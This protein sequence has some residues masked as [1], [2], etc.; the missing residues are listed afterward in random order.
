MLWPRAHRQTAG[1]ERSRIQVCGASGAAAHS[2]TCSTNELNGT[3]QFLLLSPEKTSPSK[4]GPFCDSPSVRPRNGHEIKNAA[5][6]KLW[7]VRCKWPVRLFGLE[8][9]TDRQRSVV[10]LQDVVLNR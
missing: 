5:C 1:L 10:E 3:T 8:G 4:E 6:S 9:V 2:R 7:T